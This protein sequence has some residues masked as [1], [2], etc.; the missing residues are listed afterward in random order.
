LRSAGR[1]RFIGTL[2]IATG[3]VAPFAIEAIENAYALDIKREFG[4]AIWWALAAL[5]GVLVA[6]SFR[7]RS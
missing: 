2:L 1:L 3:V 5:G 6:L 7:R 4:V